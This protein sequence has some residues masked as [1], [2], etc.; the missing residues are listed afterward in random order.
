MPADD[1]RREKD[2]ELEDDGPIEVLDDDDIAVLK[3]YVC[4]LIS[5]LPD[6]FLNVLFHNSETHVTVKRALYEGDPRR[7]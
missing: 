7:R 3:S 4:I 5:Q 1:D 6:A 2:K